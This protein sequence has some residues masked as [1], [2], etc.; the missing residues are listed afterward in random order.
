MRKGEPRRWLPRPFGLVS[1]AVLL[2]LAGTSIALFA[3]SRNLVDDQE[4]RLLSERTAEVAA[5]LSNSVNNIS[6][7]LQVLAPIAASSQPDSAA[8]F[9]ASAMLTTSF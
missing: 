9:T 6:S 8:L 5:L 7:S 2:V 3:V 4:R 1:W